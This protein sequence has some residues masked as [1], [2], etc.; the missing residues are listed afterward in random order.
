[1][2][3]LTKAEERVM[4]ILWKLEKAFTREVG[5][6][7]KKDPPSYTTVAT[8]LTVLE[9]KGFVKQEMIG[10]AKRYAP[11]ISKT[12]YSEFTMNNVLGKYFEGSLS[13]LVSFFTERKDLDIDELEEII[14]IIEDKKEEK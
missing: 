4:Q 11:A 8:V 10:N 9:Q 13:R 1:M 6:E 12:A 14:K 2:K 7:F 3:E 5:N